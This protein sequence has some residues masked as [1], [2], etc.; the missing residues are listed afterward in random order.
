M[1]RFLVKIRQL[2]TRIVRVLSEQELLLIAVSLLL[3][4]L[5]GIAICL[6]LLSIFYNFALFFLAIVILLFVWVGWALI[7]IVQ[8][9][10]DFYF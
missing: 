4:F 3:M 9:E 2:C 6:I 10:E 7:G 5:L 8:D 1:K